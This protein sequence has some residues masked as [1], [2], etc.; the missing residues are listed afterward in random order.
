MPEKYKRHK[1]KGYAGV[2]FIEGKAVA[3]G[4]PE[5]IFYIMYRKDRKLIEERVGRQYQHDMTAARASRIRTNRIEGR[6]LPNTEKRAEQKAAK[7]A[8]ASRWTINRLWDRYCEDHTENKSL[9]NEKLKYEKC[10]RSGLG[11]KEPGELLPLDVDRLRLKLQRAKK[12]TMAAR[13]LELLRRAINFGVKKQ[14]VSPI[15]FRIEIPRLNNQT[16]ECLTPEQISKLHEV[17]DA[18]QDQVAANVMRLALFTG[19]RRSEIFGLKRD[20]LD[21]E[22]GFIRL[23]DPK[24]GVDQTIPMSEAARSVFESIDADEGNTYVFPGRL[25]SEHLT[26]CRKSFARIAKAAGFPPGFRP[27]HGLRHTFASTLASSGKIDM[28]TLQRLMTHKSAAMTQ[29]YAHLHDS[30]LHRAASV[31]ADLMAGKPSKDAK[32]AILSNKK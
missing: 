2:Y 28:Y 5:R 18:D 12:K 13:V 17:L 25:P 16:T 20:D 1:I 3:T 6:E 10:L 4:K 26:D 15:G 14:L 24:P 19:M 32:M 22:R 31:A 27:L 29:R 23:D 9:A 8:E 30:T 21:F 11:M 7:E